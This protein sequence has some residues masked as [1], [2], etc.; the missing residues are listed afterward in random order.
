MCRCYQP[1]NFYTEYVSHGETAN[2][3]RKQGP[4]WYLSVAW[5]RTTRKHTNVVD[6]CAQA[7][8]HRLHDILIAHPA[9][10]LLPILAPVIVLHFFVAIP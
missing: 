9:R 5:A 8:T 1:S 6:A 4:M 2:I 3:V 10:T 7:A